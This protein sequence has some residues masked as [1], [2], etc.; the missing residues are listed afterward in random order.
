MRI[1]DL[2]PRLEQARHPVAP[3]WPSRARA[4]RL[5]GVAVASL[6]LA[7][8]LV[9]VLEGGLIGIDDASPVYLLA[10]VAVGTLGGTWPAIATAIVAFLI[11]DLLFTEPRFSLVVADPREWLD[12]LLFLFVALAIGRLVAIQHARAAE[13]TRRAAEANSLFALSRSL[14]T[15]TST[16]DAAGEIAERLKR[17]ASM[18]R[19]VILV[20][21]PGMERVLVD[22]SPS[23]PP[24]VPSIVTTLARAPGSEPARWVRTHA[25]GARPV[26]GQ[27]QFR[28]R[29]EVDGVQSG[30]LVALRDR[31]LGLPDRGATRIL[32]LG[33][34]QLAISLRRDQLRRTAVDLEVARQGDSLK[35]ALIDSVSHDLRTPLASIRATAGGLAD[36]AV[37][38][39]DD[40]RRE[41]A[42]R[43]DA[44]AARLDS[45]VRGLLDLGRLA[46]GAI[47]PDLEP[48][49]PWSIIRPAVDRLRPALGERPV[50][51]DVADDLPPILT[52]AALLDIVMTNLVDNAARHAPAPAAVSIVAR[53]TG[54]GRLEIA[55]EDGGPG[56]PPAALDRLFD[57]FERAD[58]MPVGPRHGLGIGLSVVK[59]LV[60]A[61]GGT[62]RAGT[63][64]LGGLAVTISLRV[65]LSPEDGP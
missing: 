37:P 62:V 35:T 46:S 20:G 50:H 42:A 31:T 63:S 28:V 27:E 56:V 65:A 51:V 58:R 30:T 43:I 10:V 54:G 4:A 41:A 19:I 39:T 17:D 59:G 11:Y 44:E 36:P 22:T 29:I 23:P 40:A 52:D 12:L 25:A 14:A 9:A 5:G 16:E 64:V 57:R 1:A 55:V 24:P 15:A 13:A 33:A 32:A 6:L 3:A 60:E 18:E 26:P 45:L 2:G 61:M 49:D 7:T 8:G 53:T 34:D 21:P 47:H 38:W 48:H